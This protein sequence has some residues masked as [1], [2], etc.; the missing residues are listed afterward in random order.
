[1]KT[2]I[3]ILALTFSFRASAKSLVDST[4]IFGDVDAKISAYW[5]KKYPIQ[6]QVECHQPADTP[7]SD[8]PCFKTVR[9]EPRIAVRVY[10]DRNDYYAGDKTETESYD[11]IVE[12]G[13]IKVSQKNLKDL[14]YL[15]VTTTTKVELIENVSCVGDIPNEECVTESRVGP[16]TRTRLKLWRK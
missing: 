10:L 1:M 15:E 11:I 6:E 5:I 14:F 8:Q 16:V 13:D 4:T 3:A 7:F 9:K 12:P 2:L